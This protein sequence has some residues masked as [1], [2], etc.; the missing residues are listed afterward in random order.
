M[1]LTIGVVLAAVHSDIL[2]ATR[3]NPRSSPSIVVHK[4]RASF[5]RPSLFPSR[6]KL[7]T[8]LG[9]RAGMDSGVIRI[10]GAVSR[11][12]PNRRWCLLRLDGG[13][14]SSGSVFGQRSILM[15]LPF[16]LCSG[17]SVTLGFGCAVNA[18]AIPVRGSGVVVNIIRASKIIL[19]T[20]PSSRETAVLIFKGAQLAALARTVG[21]AGRSWPGVNT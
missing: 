10:A 2:L 4:V 19:S 15:P 8:T 13:G 21:A 11:R 6:G 5:R 3:I 7:A 9:S 12:S 17:L 14:T 20:F 1:N 18:R 16:N